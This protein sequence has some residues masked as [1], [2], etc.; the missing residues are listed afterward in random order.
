MLFFLQSTT[1]HSTQFHRYKSLCPYW[2]SFERVLRKETKFFLLIKIYKSTNKSRTIVKFL[3]Q[4]YKGFCWIKD[5]TFRFMKNSRKLSIGQKCS[6]ALFV[7]QFMPIPTELLGLNLDD[8]GQIPC[9]SSDAA[10]SLLAH[11]EG[12]ERQRWGFFEWISFKIF[13]IFYRMV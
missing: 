7:R 2:L 1:T 12:P 8:H 9:S 4:K 10:Q 5:P 11:L 3:N 6:L 13:S